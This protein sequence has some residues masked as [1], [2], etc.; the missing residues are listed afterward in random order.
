MLNAVVRKEVRKTVGNLITDFS[1]DMIEDTLANL[2]DLTAEF[3]EDN[4]SVMLRKIPKVYDTL[5]IGDIQQLIESGDEAQA[6]K[7]LAKIASEEVKR[8]E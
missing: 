3:A 5:S 1:E 6:N 7:V 2:R 8:S 4:I